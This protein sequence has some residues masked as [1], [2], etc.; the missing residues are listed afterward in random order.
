METIEAAFEITAWDEVPYESPEDG[1]VLK[2][3]T[4]RK[5]YRGILEAESTAELLMC[6]AADGSA[7][8]VASERVV[9]RL[10]ERV[11]SF[12][13]QH[14]GTV[15]GDDAKPFGHVVPGSGT[16]ALHGLRGEATFR[17][18]E[19]GAVLTLRYAFG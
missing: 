1:P 6:Q 17:H 18:D 2:R 8:Y 3:A 13:L 19:N 12:V 4:V 15:E 5:V 7:G 10:G 16:G 11:G 9:G 14:G